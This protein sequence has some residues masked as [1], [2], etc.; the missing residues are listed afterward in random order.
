MCRSSSPVVHQSRLSS[1]VKSTSLT[2]LK[3]LP[4]L[5]WESLRSQDLE[6]VIIHPFYGRDVPRHLGLRRYLTSRDEG[7]DGEV[8]E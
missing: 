5:R 7:G 3:P 4:L 8:V 6:L 1:N 2:G